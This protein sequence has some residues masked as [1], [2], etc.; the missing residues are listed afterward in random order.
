MITLI[1]QESSLRV[2]PYHVLT[3]D[4]R[5]PLHKPEPRKRKPKESKRKAL[6]TK[7]S[8][9]LGKKATIP[10]HHKKRTRPLEH[11]KKK[12]LQIPT[13]EEGITAQRGTQNTKIVAIGQEGRQR[14]GRAEKR[15]PDPRTKRRGKGSPLPISK[16]IAILG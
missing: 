10:T 16:G 11:E 15:R 4:K 3:R 5:L 12:K 7:D 6:H 14:M 13:E 8:K 1:L 2:Q 9:K